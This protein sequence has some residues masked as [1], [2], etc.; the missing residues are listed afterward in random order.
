MQKA[1]KETYLLTKVLCFLMSRF[2]K[3]TPKQVLTGQ[4]TDEYLLDSPQ[5]KHQN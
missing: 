5:G 4:I 3:K 2:C 1:K